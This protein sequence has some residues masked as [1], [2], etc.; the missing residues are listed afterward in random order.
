MEIHGGYADE[1]EVT[2]AISKQQAS[3]LKGLTWGYFKTEHLYI[4]L[5]SIGGAVFP[6]GDSEEY[7][8]RQL[9]MKP[10]QTTKE[11]SALVGV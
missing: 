6:C 7:I 2:H 11:P 8:R 10:K 5:L 1:M 9:N 4:A 3:L